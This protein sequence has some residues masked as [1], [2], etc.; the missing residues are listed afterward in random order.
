M[1]SEMDFP[2]C[3]RVIAVNDSLITFVPEG[4]N[5]QLHLNPTAPYTGPMNKPVTGFIRAQGRKIWTVPSG[6]NFIT[7]ISGPPRIV[8]GRVRYVSDA[9]IVLQASTGVIVELPTGPN[10]IDLTTGALGIGAL[11]NAT[12]LPGAT[13]ELAATTATV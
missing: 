8:Q 12:L 10:S 4:T 6:G 9:L 11:A 13:F 7:P 3:G 2:A 1:A 5:Y